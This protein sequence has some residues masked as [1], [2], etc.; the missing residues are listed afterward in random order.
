VTVAGLGLDLVDVAGFAEQLGT[1]G[2]AFAAATFTRAELQAASG[3]AGAAQHLAARFAAKEAF[4]KAWSTALAGR[5]PV[6]AEVDWRE[7]EVRTDPWGRPVLALHGA[8]AQAVTASVGPVRA[9][10]SLTHE[11][12]T[13]AAVVVL[14]QGEDPR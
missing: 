11:P 5:A 2:S 1:I 13:A 8:L 9:H 12:T 10:V 14:E 7:V 6:L 4:V 3:S